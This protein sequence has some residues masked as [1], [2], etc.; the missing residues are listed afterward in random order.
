MLQS[1]YRR[2]ESKLFLLLLLLKVLYDATCNT[3]TAPC[4]VI[5]KP[6]SLLTCTYVVEENATSF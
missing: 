5:Y 4:H 6:P 1:S 2:C 3:G